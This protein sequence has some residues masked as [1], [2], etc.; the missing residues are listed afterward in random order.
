MFARKDEKA[1]FRIGTKVF[2]AYYPGTVYKVTKKEWDLNGVL[3]YSI[4]NKTEDRNGL[5]QKYLSRV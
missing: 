3:F 5:K 2:C 4:S 1:M